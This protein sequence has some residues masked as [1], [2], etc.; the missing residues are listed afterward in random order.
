M[1]KRRQQSILEIVAAGGV[2]SQGDIVR[3]LAAMGIEANQATVS[4]D[5]QELGLVRVP[6][7]VLGHRYAL[8]GGVST[9]SW[10]DVEYTLAQH[11]VKVDGNASLI[12]LKT[13]PGHAHMVAAA[14][15]RLPGDDIV[16]TIAGDDTL[17]IVPRDKRVKKWLME[18]F[19]SLIEAPSRRPRMQAGAVVAAASPA[20]RV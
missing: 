2:A 4:R 6:D 15:D 18:R 7:A 14:L 11:V 20:V 16:G 19:A 1:K 17:L 5:V 10:S 9:A 12:V 8:P 3:E 13:P